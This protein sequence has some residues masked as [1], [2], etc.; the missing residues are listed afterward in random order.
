MHLD[1]RELPMLSAG[2]LP[3]LQSLRERLRMR[4][5]ISK[6]KRPVQLAVTSRYRSL[7]AVIYEG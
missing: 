5:R 4:C 2:S 7:E 3:R 1:D 6:G